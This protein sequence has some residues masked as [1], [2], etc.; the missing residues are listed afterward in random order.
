MYIVSMGRVATEGTFPN[1]VQIKQRF[2][3]VA[4]VVEETEDLLRH[5]GGA[6][7][8]VFRH[9]LQVGDFASRL[10]VPVARHVL[11]QPLQ[12]QVISVFVA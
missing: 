3:L 9:L 4:D 1:P 11:P 2:V 12:V 7:V 8:V 6:A 5:A 10:A